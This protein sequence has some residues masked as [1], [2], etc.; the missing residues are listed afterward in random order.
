MPVKEADAGASEKVAE[1]EKPAK[2]KYVPL[3]KVEGEIRKLLARERA[4]ARIEEVL[5]PLR[6]MM[7]QYRDKKIRYDVD[8]KDRPAELDF[9]ALAKKNGLSTH[10]TGLISAMQAVQLDI[11]RSNVESRVPLVNYAFEKLPEFR[12][13]TSQ[14]TEG[15]VYLLWKTKDVKDRIPKLDDKG[16]SQRVSWAWKLNR[17]RRLAIKEAEKLAAEARKS[18]KS[19]KDTFAKIPGVAVTTTAPFSWMTHGAVPAMMSQQPPK[20][21]EVDGVDMAGED[22]MRTV[23]N[24]DVGQVGIAM[25]QPQTAVYVVRPTRVNPTSTVLWELFLVDDF[26]KYASV[27]Y[28]DQR[29]ILDSWQDELETAAGL[30]WQRKPDQPR[31]AEEEEEDDDE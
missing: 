17:A 31:Q 16:V 28:G 9:A 22:F 14:D 29:Q 23:F 21:S 10:R 5:A 24:L 13:A 26:S 8:K 25:N 30:T 2:P 1:P 12:P 18:K 11:G 7:R 27:A 15:S 19:L 6:D 3:E 4:G 20:L